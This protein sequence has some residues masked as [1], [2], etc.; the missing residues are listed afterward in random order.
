MEATFGCY[1]LE[2]SLPECDKDLLYDIIR[3]WRRRCI[4]T[5]TG[6]LNIQEE[7]LG[8]NPEMMI[9]EL[10]SEEPIRKEKVIIFL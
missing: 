10:T 8:L 1:Y 9:T 3:R 6:G 7:H 5:K 4:F 2:V